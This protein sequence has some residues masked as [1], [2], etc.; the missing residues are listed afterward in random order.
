MNQNYP[1][2]LI[3]II[4]AAFSLDARPGHFLRRALAG[5]NVPKIT[6]KRIINFKNQI[7]FTQAYVKVNQIFADKAMEAVDRLGRQ[8]NAVLPLIW[9]HDYHL[10]LA[11]AIIRQVI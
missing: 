6:N 3:S 2:K 11:A 9:V 10:T 4:L 8:G 1:S 5:T 7:L